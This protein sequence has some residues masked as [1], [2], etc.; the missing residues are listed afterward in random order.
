M[1]VT[2]P[3]DKLLEKLGH[4]VT[5]DTDKQRLVLVGRDVGSPG[6]RAFKSYG[7]WTRFNPANKHKGAPTNV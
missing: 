7:P 5:Y 6:H 1:R 4:G 3:Q 2:K